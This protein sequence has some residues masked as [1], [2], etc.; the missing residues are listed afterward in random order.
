MTWMSFWTLQFCPLRYIPGLDLGQL[1]RGVQQ[2][3]EESRE[4]SLA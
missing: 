3:V 2:E 1:I 4:P